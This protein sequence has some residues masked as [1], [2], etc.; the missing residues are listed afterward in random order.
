MCILPTPSYEVAFGHDPS[1]PV[2]VTVKDVMPSVVGCPAQVTANA[3]AGWKNEIAIRAETITLAANPI[4][5][6]R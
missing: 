5:A 1:D 3:G 2:M 6:R 4:P